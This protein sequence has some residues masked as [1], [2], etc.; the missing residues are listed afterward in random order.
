MNKQ[1]LKLNPH[2]GG[3]YMD[4]PII[5]GAGYFLIHSP[6]LLMQFG[7]TPVTERVKHPDSEFLKKLSTNIRSYEQAVS[8]APNQAFIGNLLPD[9]LAKIERPWFK[10]TKEYSRQGTFG[11]IMPEDEFYGLMKLSDAFDLV[12]LESGFAANVMEKLK[13]HPLVSKLDLTPLSKG[14]SANEIEAL[15]SAHTADPLLLYDGKTI[16]CVKRAHDIDDTLQA[17]VLAENLASKASAVLSVL[18]LFRNAGIN[19]EDVDYVIECS[20]EACGDMNQR[21]GGNFAKAI[22][23]VSGCKNATG[24]DMRGFC[25]GP[26]HAVVSAA[27]LV[28]A[29]VYHNVVVVGG[30]AVAKLGMNSRDHINKGYPVLEDTLGAFALLIS[31]NDGKNP[32]IRTDL[33][34][35]HTVGTGSSP[36]SVIQAIVVDPLDRAG[37]KISDVDKFS[38]EMQNPE[39]TEAAGAGNVPLANYKMIAALAVKRGELDRRDIMEFA[40]RHGMPGFAPTQGHVPSGVPF[41]GLGRELILSGKINRTMIIGK[42]SLFLGRMTNQFDGVSFIMEKNL[43][44]TQPE[45]EYDPKQIR[46][47]IADAFRD[48]A[49]SFS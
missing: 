14:V 30:G 1:Y 13:S 11:E 12:H 42:G 19:P 47:M 15:V 25:A 39:I 44:K 3:E 40:E 34:G 35:R 46:K 18:G 32:I 48:L 17:H 6:G 4:F 31:E 38:V 27:A 7:S 20:E 5:K 33:I 22:A 37:L 2:N 28:K 26:A 16:G 41:M 10:Q 24:A 43:G 21:G 45:P 23:E 8:Y 9:E 49:K 29:G 36:Q